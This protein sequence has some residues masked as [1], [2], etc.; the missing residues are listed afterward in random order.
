MTTFRQVVAERGGMKLHPVKA[1]LRNS[2]KPARPPEFV[3]IHK[4]LLREVNR[5][6]VPYG[7]AV[8]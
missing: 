4:Q 3:T 7:R 8:R 1:H 5:K 2:P 6:R